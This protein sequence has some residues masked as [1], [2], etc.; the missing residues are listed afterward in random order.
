MNETLANLQFKGEL[1]R[2]VECTEWSG[3]LSLSGYFDI[4]ATET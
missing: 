2:Q 4:H 3:A 1:S